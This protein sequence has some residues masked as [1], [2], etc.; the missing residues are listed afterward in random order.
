LEKLWSEHTDVEDGK[1]PVGKVAAVYW[2][3]GYILGNDQTQNLEKCLTEEYG[4]WTDKSTRTQ[5]F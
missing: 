3:A 4:K 2:N 1:I 5:V